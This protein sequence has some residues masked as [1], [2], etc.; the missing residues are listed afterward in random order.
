[1]FPL[2]SILYP[3]IEV[4]GQFHEDHVF[5]KSRFSRRRL[6]DAGVPEGQ[7]EAFQEAVN[8]LPNLQLLPGP[9]NV[10][11]L[12]DLPLDWAKSAYPRDVERGAYLA[13]HDLDGLPGD[14]SDFLDFYETRRRRMQDRLTALLAIDTT[15]KASSSVGTS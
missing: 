6:I 13:L 15:N 5:P 4:R 9:V 8:R 3:G 1:V 14:L 11:K 10:A 7:I 12:A 2:L